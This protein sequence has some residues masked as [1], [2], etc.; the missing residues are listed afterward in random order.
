MLNKW[1]QENTTYNS[2]PPPPPPLPR[3]VRDFASPGALAEHLE[4]LSEDEEA[5]EAYFQWRGNST[6]AERFQEV[7]WFT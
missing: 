3:K 4:A 6:E 2:A 5:Y 7:R 1:P